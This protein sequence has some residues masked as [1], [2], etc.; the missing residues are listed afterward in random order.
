MSAAIVTKSLPFQLG[1]SMMSTAFVLPLS[2]L[3]VQ[4]F[5]RTKPFMSPDEE[6]IDG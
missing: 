1:V 5:R 6:D 2:L 4:L 3:V